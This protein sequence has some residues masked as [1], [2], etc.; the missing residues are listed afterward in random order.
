MVINTS[1]N[2]DLE[3]M[4]FFPGKSERPPISAVGEPPKQKKK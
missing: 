2:D 3:F 1:K 4:T